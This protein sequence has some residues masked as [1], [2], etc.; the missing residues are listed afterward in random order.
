MSYGFTPFQGFSQKRRHTACLLSIRLFNF[1]V[2]AEN[3]T[4]LYVAVHLQV[5]GIFWAGI[6]EYYNTTIVTITVNIPSSS[7]CAETNALP[8]FWQICLRLYK[9]SPLFSPLVE[10]FSLNISSME[11]SI[12]IP[13]IRQMTRSGNFSKLL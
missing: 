4:T 11:F 10:K 7:A 9:P 1:S 3:L 2:N 8:L 6:R 13:A 5:Y 12:I